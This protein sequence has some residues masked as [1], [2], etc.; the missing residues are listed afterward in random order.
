MKLIDINLLPHKEKKRNAFTYSV[1]GTILFIILLA[2]LML[3]SWQNTLTETERTDAEIDT[4]KKI[5]EVQQTKVLGAEASNSIGALNKAVQ[6]MVDYPVKTVPLLNELISLLPERGFIRELEYSDRT[7]INVA[8]QF[9]SSREAAFYLSRLKNVDWIKEG[10]I[11]EITTEEV[12]ESD[13]EDIL[14][15]YLAMYALHL[16]S[17]KLSALLS[18]EGEEE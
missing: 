15:R 16:D 4:T 6:D 10:E 5:I 12:G 3:L 18:E 17:D 9:D 11:L 1:T 14:P 13:E 7:I 8:V 2:A